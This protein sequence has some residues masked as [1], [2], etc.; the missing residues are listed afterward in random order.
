[1]EF[2]LSKLK[3]LHSSLKEVPKKSLFDLAEIIPIGFNFSVTKIA[4]D[5]SV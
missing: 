5:S 2:V 3:N 4:P 1:M